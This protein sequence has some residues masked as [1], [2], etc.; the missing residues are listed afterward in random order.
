MPDGRRRMAV[1]RTHVPILKSKAQVEK[2]I[3]D[4]YFLRPDAVPRRPRNV[5]PRHCIYT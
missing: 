1:G 3:Q 4:A 2:T 5:S